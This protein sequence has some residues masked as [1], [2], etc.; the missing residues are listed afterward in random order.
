MNDEKN[1]GGVSPQREEINQQLAAMIRHDKEMRNNGIDI[2]NGT[3]ESFGAHYS[4]P[5]K[6]DDY[7]GES[8]IIEPE[9]NQKKK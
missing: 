5:S 3:S 9:Y 1:Y 2:H 7:V 6:L 8:P 4:T